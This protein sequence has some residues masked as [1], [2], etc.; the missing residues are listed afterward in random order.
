MGREVQK[1]ADPFCWKSFLTVGYSWNAL[2]LAGWWWWWSWTCCW[3]SSWV[4]VLTPRFESASFVD[5]SSQL[6]P[7]IQ[8]LAKKLFFFLLFADV[9]H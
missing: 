5:M 8:D 6:W 2:D 9:V 4:V 3:D 1:D 7:F